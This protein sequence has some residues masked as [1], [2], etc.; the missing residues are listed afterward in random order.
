[1]T[2]YSEEEAYRYEQAAAWEA[3]CDLWDAMMPG[4]ETDESEATDPERF[5]SEADYWTPTARER[6]E[7]QVT[8]DLLAFWD[9]Y[10]VLPL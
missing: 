3:D 2:Y 10:H 1:M 6:E 7:L 5:V 4:W 8:D 9:R